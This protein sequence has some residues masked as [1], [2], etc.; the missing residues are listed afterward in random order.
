[1]ISTVRMDCSFGYISFAR[2]AY[3]YG[4]LFPIYGWIHRLRSR[5]GSVGD[6]AHI[7]GKVTRVTLR[8]PTHTH[9]L[10]T[11]HYLPTTLLHYHGLHTR[12]TSYTFLFTARLV[13]VGCYH[14]YWLDYDHYRLLLRWRLR[15][16]WLPRSCPSPP[17]FV[18]PR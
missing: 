18:T 16:R 14:V 17:L 5:C 6:P 7:R 15:S 8:A 2:V 1:M 12:Y 9:T 3:I 13:T 11:P 4:S 10:R